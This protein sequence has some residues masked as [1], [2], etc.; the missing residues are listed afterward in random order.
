MWQ[1]VY[2]SEIAKFHGSSP[3]MW[4]KDAKL[5]SNGRNPYEIFVFE[6]LQLRTGLIRRT[7]S[8]SW[9]DDLLIMSCQASGSCWSEKGAGAMVSLGLHPSRGF[10]GGTSA[11]E[12]A[13]QCR[14]HK[15]LWLNPWVRKMSWR[16][17]QHP[18]SVFLPGEFYRQ[19]S[20]AGWSP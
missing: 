8:S 19:K 3:C 14:R 2:V 7:F 17:A 20:L 11:K 10:P 4:Q 13:C 12:P 6:T 9:K 1:R 18:T 15:R 5:E 16:R